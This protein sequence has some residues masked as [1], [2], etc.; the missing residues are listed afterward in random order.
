M[1]KRLIGGLLMGV[2]AKVNSAR[3]KF[4]DY[5]QN[6]Q[7]HAVNRNKW[8]SQ[9]SLPGFKQD[10]KGA[11][12]GQPLFTN[13]MKWRDQV[14]IQQ[15]YFFVCFFAPYFSFLLAGTQPL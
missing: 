10:L 13:R 14:G 3:R 12:I 9:D 2:S 11:V 5:A 15:P 8:G 4:F 6:G 7:P 1:S